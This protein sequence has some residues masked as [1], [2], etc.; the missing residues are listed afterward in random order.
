MPGV[1]ASPL[2][3]FLKCQRIDERLSSWP[4]ETPEF[5]VMHVQV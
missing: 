1:I 5:Y 3:I 2:R 4:S